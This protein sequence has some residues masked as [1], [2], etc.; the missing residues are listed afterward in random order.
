MWGLVTSILQGIVGPL[1]TYLNKRVD[2]DMQVHVVTNKTLGEV[3]GKGIDAVTNADKL[4]AETRQREGT[5][6]PTVLMMLLVLAPFVWHQWQVVL[7]SSRWIPS[8]DLWLGFIPYPTVAEH[9]IGSWRV[10]TLGKPGP[11]GEPSP[12]DQTQQAIF[13]SLFVGATAAVVAV[14]TVRAIKR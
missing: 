8:W 14:A 9:Q 11:N 1:F 7:D 4:N 12:W 6:G 10:A 3:A 5:W 2:A 13:Q